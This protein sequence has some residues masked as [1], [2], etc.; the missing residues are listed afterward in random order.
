MITDAMFYG[1]LTG[2]QK[3]VVEKKLA[4]TIREMKDNGIED[5]TIFK[6]KCTVAKSM[7]DRQLLNG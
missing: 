6:L 3:E 7:F 2:H 1:Q 5:Y 4:S